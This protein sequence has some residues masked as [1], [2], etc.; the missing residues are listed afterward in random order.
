MCFLFVLCQ[1]TKLQW[2]SQVACCHWAAKSFG[3]DQIW[4]HEGGREEYYFSILLLL[5][6]KRDEPKVT[7][8]NW[9]LDSVNNFTLFNQCFVL[10]SNYPPHGT[11]PLPLPQL[12]HHIQ[13]RYRAAK[14]AYES[15]LQTEDLPA[16][17]KATTLQQLGKSVHRLG[18][19][20]LSTAEVWVELE[21]KANWEDWAKTD[22][23]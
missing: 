6:C 10:S 1:N 20:K 14:E 16:Q 15:L 5:C 7:D 17:V 23:H 18:L 22:E 12:T 9:I 8:L 19:V 11:L 3:C 21:Y 2:K 13:K 4:R